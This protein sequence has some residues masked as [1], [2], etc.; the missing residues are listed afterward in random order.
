[1]DNLFFSNYETTLQVRC[2]Q[3]PFFGRTLKKRFVLR[4]K[5]TTVLPERSSTVYTVLEASFCRALRWRSNP[6]TL[7][8]E[9]RT[10]NVLHTYTPCNVTN[11]YSDFPRKWSEASG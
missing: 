10:H 2:L 8:L 9:T 1:M 11:I 3:D 5:E 6:C 7:L 4:S